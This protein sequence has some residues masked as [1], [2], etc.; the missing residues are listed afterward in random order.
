MRALSRFVS[1]C[2]LL[3]MLATV[4]SPSFG[5]EAV[6]SM[7]GHAHDG[8]P[9]TD[10]E[11]A[12]HHPGADQPVAVHHAADDADDCGGCAGHDSVACGDTMHHCC[13]GHV[14]GHL[15]GGVGQGLALMPAPGRDFLPVGAVDRY[16]SR[17]PDGLERPPR[18]SAV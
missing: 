7:A 10:A 6:Q 16:A 17:I 9:A 1:R 18:S 4:F 13:P 8:M 3:V 2:L 15:P 12:G 11:H 5:W 14:L